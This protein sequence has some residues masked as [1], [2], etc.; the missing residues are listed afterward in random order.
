MAHVG[1]ADRA[2][3]EGRAT[4]GLFGVAATVALVVAVVFAEFMLL[5]FV[6]H[7]GDA[8]RSQRLV[9]THLTGVL[10]S[11]A[12]SATTLAEARADVQRLAAAGVSAGQLAPLRAAL[13]T[14]RPPVATLR[15]DSRTLSTT[16]G[17]R[18]DQIDEQ[19]D[20]IYVALLIVASFGWMFWFRRLVARHKA[21]QRR[22]TEQEARS[23]GERRLA[24]L[25]HGS[26]DVIAVLDADSRIS[27][28]TPSSQSVLGWSPDELVGRRW[29]DEVLRAEDV[30]AFVQALAGRRADAAVSMH[31]R[32]RNGSTLYLEGT[33]T[34]LL[35]DDT[36][37][38]LV[39]TVRDI[40]A[41]REMES[42][43]T[44]HAFHDELTGLANR[45]LFADRLE[46][47]MQRND[48]GVAVLFF[49][50]DD[51]KQINDSVGH[52]VGDAV[53]VEVG[54]RLTRILR[55]EDT[56]A[57]LGGDEFAVL[58][59]DSDLASGSLVAER[60]QAA[61]AEPVVV[62]GTSHEI[63]ASIGLSL[64]DGDDI[65]WEEVL[66][67]ADV[68]M[69][70][71]KDRGKAGIAVYEPAL[72]EES[73]QR[74]QLQAD[75]QRALR[76]DELV[77]HYQ[78]GVELR[79]GRIVGFEAL[80]RWQR[81]GH[82]L[83]GPLEFIPEAERCGL[84]VP[85]GAWVL[86]TACHAAAA[87]QD[88]HNHPT[89]SVNVA[90]AQLCRDDFVDTVFEALESS[91]LAPDRLCLEITES[92]LM[93]DLA[94][95][96]P[97]L[98]VLR[99]C[100]VR[101]AVDDFGTGYSS[102][103]YLSKLPVDVLKVDRSFVERVTLDEQDASVTHAILA[104]SSAMHLTTVAEGIEQTD[105]A[106]WLASANCAIG[107]GFLW[108]KA[109]P[110]SDA[111]SLLRDSHWAG[112]VVAPTPLHPVDDAVASSPEVPVAQGVEHQSARAS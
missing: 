48:S 104:M 85:L 99:E 53:L 88:E 20:V 62:D 51:F 15:A 52:G 78:P 63:T 68:A 23:A 66:R 41:R 86:R 5:S 84:I 72:H 87:L 11:P 8:V 19:A 32:H 10:A 39:L 1:G 22:V 42:Q 90:V 76:G 100:G 43:L 55:P 60:L 45:R 21:L 40:T 71:A 57:R 24:A 47:A 83:V 28:V 3:A 103:S 37:D 70:L 16:L 93:G 112:T 74:V 101:V 81:P 69:Y 58:M 36:V 108:S 38:G 96:V 89:M 17:D 31:A 67:N 92:T 33:L 49:D 2:K 46:H 107:Q 97:R 13:A 110:I 65:T 34:N 77:L 7:R 79:T 54:T 12:Q 27:F 105:Q 9:A 75:L 44:H 94:R 64:A 61:L 98:A 102:L 25:V 106:E 80:V 29:I 14:T 82:G 95:I 109:V 91:G 73:L 6:Y 4:A 35:G 18:S 111:K 50:L 59:E 26:S 30:A 56:A